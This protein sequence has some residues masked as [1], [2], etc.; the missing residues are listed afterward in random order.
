MFD[1]LS[2]FTT[3]FLNTIQNTTKG[4]NQDPVVQ[5]ILRRSGNFGISVGG[6]W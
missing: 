3:E 5:A 1:K 2:N 4:N 6:A